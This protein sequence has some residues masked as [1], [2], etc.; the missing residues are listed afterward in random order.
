MGGG[1]STRILAALTPRRFGKVR[2]ELTRPRLVGFLLVAG[3]G[4]F[5]HEL[6]VPCEADDRPLDPRLMTDRQ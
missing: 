6:V 5:Q 2:E 4:E 3:G 1:V